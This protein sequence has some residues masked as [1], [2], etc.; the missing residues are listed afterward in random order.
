MN[1]YSNEKICLTISNHLT[2]LDGDWG[3]SRE[4]LTDAF[5]GD[6]S[7]TEIPR[8]F[9][10]F[11]ALVWL[12]LD[13]NNIEELPKDCLP[14][15]I[16][17]LSINNNL[18]KEFPQSLG[19]LK[20]LTWLY[21]RGNDLKYLELPD[22]RSFS[23]EMIDISENSIEWIKTPL[24]NRTLRVREFYLS[25]NKLTSLPSKMFDRLEIRR[26]YLSS[27][28]IRYVDN[29]AFFGLEDSL[30]YLNLENN[31]LSAVPKAVSQLRTL[32]YL[33]LANNEIRNI[34][35]EAFQEFA[36]HLKA[37]SLATNNLDA[38]PVAALSRYF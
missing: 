31:D 32:S 20:K 2:S 6:N 23:L 9:S 29:K 5:F 37:V 13:S 35:G 18:L 7:I 25:G 4:T 14:P 19:G 27:N 3:R 21:M 8:I 34:S 1:S 17:T 10:S 12:N 30:E 11:T 16:N 28:N 22:F 36:E 24:S 26:I 38:V 15:N 33:Y